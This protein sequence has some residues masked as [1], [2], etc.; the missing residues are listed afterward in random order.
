MT[1]TDLLRG[2]PVRESGFFFDFDGTL[3][4][5]Q[6]DPATVVP[7]PGAVEALSLLT[8]RAKRVAIVSARPVE[9]LRDRFAEVP[10]LALFGL[11]GLETLVDGVQKILPEAA[12]WEPVVHTLAERARQDLPLYIE[13]KRFSL[14]VHYRRAPDLKDLAETWAVAAAHESGLAL[15]AGRMVFELA[16]PVQRDKGVVVREQLEGLRSAWYFGDDL[17]DV[18]AFRALAE[19]ARANADFVGVRVLVA[20][21]EADPQLRTE[22]DLLLPEP[23]AVPTLITELTQARSGGSR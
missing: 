23:A 12:P 6:D 18:P 15:Q 7:V 1:V 17:G 9:F 13:D 11:Y 2:V 21:A 20:S 4:P 5:I 10:S 8:A 3:A 16:A 22:A 14:V 19:R